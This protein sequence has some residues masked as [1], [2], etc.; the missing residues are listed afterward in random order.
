MSHMI[1]LACFSLVAL[2][3][4]GAGFGVRPLEARQSQS[5]PTESASKAITPKIRAPEDDK[6]TEVEREAFFGL[7]GLLNLIRADM[8][9]SPSERESFTRG[10]AA[11]FKLEIEDFNRLMPI[12]ESSKR[13]IEGV[14]SEAIAYA[15]ALPPGRNAEVHKLESFQAR[16]ANLIQLARDQVQSSLSHAGWLAIQEFI[17][18]KVNSQQFISK[19][20]S[21][22]PKQ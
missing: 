15:N 22:G 4:A 13:Q 11:H 1:Q 17:R 16:R 21:S 9:A 7:L 14:R 18:S 12:A 19:P 5:S 20:L 8:D 6:F 10:A 3:A 2:I